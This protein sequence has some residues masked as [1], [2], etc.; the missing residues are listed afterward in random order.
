MIYDLRFRNNTNKGFIALIS[1]V[2]ISAILLIVATTLS[3][4]SFYGRYNIFDSEMKER[5]FT[6]AEACADIAL[7]QL[8]IDSG[9]SGNATTTI[10]SDECHIGPVTASGSERIFKTRA[11]YSDYHSNLRVTVDSSTLSVI[12]WEETP[13]F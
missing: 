4:S 12:A 9:Y 3:L 7:V 8:A 2:L 13:N 6:L 5:S 11:I 10:D 1:A